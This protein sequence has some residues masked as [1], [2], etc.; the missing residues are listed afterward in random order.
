MPQIDL[1]IFDCDGVLVDSE[2]L[3]AKIGSQLLKQT[4]YEISPEELSERYAGLIFRDILK[5]VEQETEKPVSAYLIDQMTNLFREKIATELHAIDGIREAIEIIQT[6]YP[7]CICSNAKSVD[8]KEMLS[9]VG[10]YDLFND[11]DKIFS[12]PEVGTKKLNPPLM[13]FFL[14]HNNYM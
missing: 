4:G 13:F 11:K 2:Y 5:Q 10:L 6:R 1:V 14:P 3:A 9:T 7:Y 12:A 8:I